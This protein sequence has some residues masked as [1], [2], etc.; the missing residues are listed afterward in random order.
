MSSSNSLRV[1]L[2][3]LLMSLMKILKNICPSTDPWGQHSSLISIR[4]LSHWPLLSAYNL[5]TSSLNSPSIKSMSSQFGKNDVGAHIKCLTEFQ[6]DYI[7]GSSLV[8]WWSYDCIN[9]SQHVKDKIQFIQRNDSY[10][11]LLIPAF[12]VVFSWNVFKINADEGSLS[13][14]HHWT[15]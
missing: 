5:T 9:K 14:S 15:V 12:S 7:S 11:Y 4:I 13:I 1:H 10:S 6:I 8:H 2:T 3:L